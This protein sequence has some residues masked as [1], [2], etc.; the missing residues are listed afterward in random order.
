MPIEQLKIDDNKAEN[1]RLEMEKIE[2]LKNDV[3]IEAGKTAKSIIE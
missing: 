3:K 2:S 1:I